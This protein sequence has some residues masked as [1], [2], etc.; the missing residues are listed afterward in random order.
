MYSILFS[1][2]ATEA[3][4]AATGGSVWARMDCVGASAEVCIEDTEGGYSTVGMGA[5]IWAEHEYWDARLNAAYG[6]LLA[7]PAEGDAENHEYQPNLPSMEDALREMQRAWI[8]FRDATCAY[9][10]S[11]W[12]GGTG[13]GPAAADCLMQ[14]TAR[15]ALRLESILRERG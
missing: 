1:P 10:R 14:E 11:L 6:E 15:Q 9:E 8:P 3:C 5:C 12:G 4:L 13:G 7:R 2:E